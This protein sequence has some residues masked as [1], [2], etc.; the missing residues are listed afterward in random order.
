MRLLLLTVAMLVGIDLLVTKHH[1]T[2]HAE[3]VPGFY[4]AVGFFGALL[5]VGFSKALARWVVREED[6]YG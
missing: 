1:V 2:V 3:E 6:Y 5:I 4:A